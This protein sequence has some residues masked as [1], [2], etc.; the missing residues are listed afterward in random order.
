MKFS[1]FNKFGALNSPPV[2]DAFVYGLSKHGQQVVEHDMTADVAVIW[3]VLW[4][5]RMRPAQE[6]YTKFLSMNKPVIVLEIGCLDRDRTWKIG[7]NG[8][9]SGHFDWAKNYHRPFPKRLEV[10]PDRLT[11]NDIVICTQN[12]MSEQWRNQPITAKWIEETVN[13]VRK[14]S[15]RQ[16]Q[17]RAHPRVPV[18]FNVHNYKRVTITKPNPRSND[19][20]LIESLPNTRFLINHNSNPAI[21]AALWGVPVHVDRS[22]LA[23]DVS[24][25]DLSSIEKPTVFNR[26]D[27]LKK[28]MQTEYTTEEMM[29]ADCLDHLLTHIKSSYQL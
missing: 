2:F 20:S 1:I 22:S 5:G 15:D 8:V 21:I 4:N 14:Y 6:V 24:N 12:P 17:I 16:I 26:H 25:T 28:L 10:E 29:Q 11:G 27:W 18:Q 7:L 9:N 13:K 3:S 19:Q 23:W